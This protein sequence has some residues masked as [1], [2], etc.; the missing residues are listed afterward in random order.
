LVYITAEIGINHNGSLDLAKKLIKMAKDAGADAVK[1]QKRNPHKCVPEYM[2][3]IMRDTPWG[4]KPYIEYRELM[5]FGKKEFDEIDEYCKKLNIEWYASPWDADSIDFL[6]N[7]NL[8]KVKI[9]SAKITDVVYLHYLGEKFR[10]KT[11]ILSTGM[12][13]MEDIRRA[14]KILESYS[15]DLIIMHCVSTY[16]TPPEQLNLLMIKTLQKEFPYKIGYS[17]H[18]KNI[19]PSTVAVVLGAEY[20]ERHITLDRAM[21]GSDHAASLEKR[22]LE[23]LVRDTRIIKTILG[24]GIKKFTKEEKTMA[25]RLRI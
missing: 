17:G 25:R 16:P 12:S 18:E 14:V 4:Y 13:T 5:E 23:I 6:L 20:I 11:I 15:K 2:K 8:N 21:W 24:D 10:N 7:Y 22:G 1:F 3:K 9:P 19:L